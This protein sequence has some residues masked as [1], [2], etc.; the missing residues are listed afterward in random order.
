L[1]IA[2][3]TE[4][5]QDLSSG[6]LTTAG[7]VLDERVG[8]NNGLG[9]GA[10]LSL[11]ANTGQT[12][13][14]RV[15]GRNAAQGNFK[16]SWKLFDRPTLGSCTQC[17]PTTLGAQIGSLTIAN[18]N[19]LS[20]QSF[21]TV[22][23]G[24]YQIR[25]CKGQLIYRASE[26]YWCINAGDPSPTIGFSGAGMAGWSP[27]Q[28]AYESQTETEI[29]NACQASPLI[30]TCGGTIAMQFSDTELNDN[31]KGSAGPTFQLIQFNAA[32]FFPSIGAQ[33]TST[34]LTGT[35][36]TWSCDFGINNGI[37]A[38]LDNVTVTLLNTGGISGASA[39][40][41]VSLPASTITG[42]TFTFTAD[43]P[44]SFCTA[45]LQI[46]VCGTPVVTLEYPLF[47]TIT[48]SSTLS[49]STCFTFP[50]T[51]AS[52]TIQNVGI[53]A[54]ITSPIVSLADLG[55]S[56]VTLTG[57]SSP[58][59]CANINLSGCPSEACPTNTVGIGTTFNALLFRVLETGT[60][61]NNTFTVAIGCAGLAY[62]NF[63]VTV[64]VP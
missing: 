39:A 41:T 12:Y 26:A 52:G 36:P 64:A 15:G 22:G 14:I 40:Q 6:L 45:T 8:V 11:V 25:W 59:P 48:L 42:V 53:E 37:P 44:A 62:P 54:V 57:S 16:L 13:L 7:L 24:F 51:V 28:A 50:P 58:L 47:P 29:N 61:T 4:F 18:V 10:S 49:N 55:I 20:T 5:V 34:T 56:S 38:D 32:D 33:L 9:N 3:I 31:I 19:A 46:S 17:G 30:Q 21:P 35:N 63:T 27:V 60:L 23:A 1:N 2:N 43:L